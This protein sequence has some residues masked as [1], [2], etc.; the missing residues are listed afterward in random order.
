MAEPRVRARVPWLR[1]ILVLLVLGMTL[2][3]AAMNMLPTRIPTKREL[4]REQ[5]EEQIKYRRV[6]LVQLLHEGDQCRPP[7]AR[8]IARTLVFDGQSADAYA[9]DFA[10][11][12]GGDDATVRRWAALHRRQHLREARAPLAPLRREAALE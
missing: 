7:V 9:D 5:Q 2:A 1:L 8:A 10:R 12:C 3:N 4:Q 6:R 11:R